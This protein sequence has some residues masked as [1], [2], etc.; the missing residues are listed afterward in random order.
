MARASLRSESA[1]NPSDKALFDKLA[2]S[3]A[4]FGDAGAVRKAV[5]GFVWSKSI[6]TPIMRKKEDVSKLFDSTIPK[7]NNN[8]LHLEICCLAFFG[9]LPDEVD[10][11]IPGETEQTAEL[12]TLFFEWCSRNFPMFSRN[13][14]RNFQNKYRAQMVSSLRNAIPNAA[15]APHWVDEEFYE[16]FLHQW[17]RDCAEDKIKDDLA[18]FPI[19]ILPSV[20]KLELDE[21]R[22]LSATGWHQLKNLRMAETISMH[23]V[24]EAPDLSIFSDF[25]HLVKLNLYIHPPSSANRNPIDLSPLSTVGSL[26]HLSIKTHGLVFLGVGSLEALNL[27]SLQL[28][29]KSGSMNATDPASVRTE[30][31]NWLGA[32]S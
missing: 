13:E 22:T 16:R 32:S 4:E 10:Y 18:D 27:R 25:S 6:R 3:I 5:D 28:T 19:E 14:R 21:L 9:C 17:W 7:K 23:V 24:C 29:G 11:S 2:K 31:A 30:L 12:R 15:A 20:R 1:S 8:A 26:R